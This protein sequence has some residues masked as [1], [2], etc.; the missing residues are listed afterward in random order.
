M[1]PST[2]FTKRLWGLDTGVIRTFAITSAL[3]LAFILVKWL[4]VMPCSGIQIM[5]N[6]QDPSQQS[7]LYANTPITF[8][9]ATENGKSQVVWIFDD[10]S[11]TQTGQSVQHYFRE[12]GDYTVEAKIDGQC[13]T[14]IQ[15]HIRHQ[16]TLENLGSN[17]ALNGGNPINGIDQPKTGQSTSYFCS[18]AADAYEWSVAEDPSIPTSNSNTFQPVFLSPGTYTIQLKLNNDPSKIFRKPVSVLAGSPTP[19]MDAGMPDVSAPSQQITPVSPN[20]PPPSASSAAPEEEEEAEV[21]APKKREP[22][23]VADEE[24]KYQ[25]EQIRDKKK[26]ILDLKDYFCDG[27]ETSVKVQT[28]G[29]VLNLTQLCD[30]LQGKS[31]LLGLGGRPKIKSVRST[32]DPDTKCIVVLYVDIK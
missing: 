6:G 13:Q 10:K 28:D 15:I 5:V 8:S 7:Y 18:V 16:L 26:S 24:L 30:K 22:I 9:I 17:D 29:K 1:K 32:K 11:K 12:E 19:S 3:A 14:S 4:W 31:G 21:A 27:Y 25:L 20:L 2:L 23:I